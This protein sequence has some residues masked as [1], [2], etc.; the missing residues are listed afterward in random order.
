[1]LQI[2]AF[3]AMSNVDRGGVNKIEHNMDDLRFDQEVYIISHHRNISAGFSLNESYFSLSKEAVYNSQRLFVVDFVKISR[4][5]LY[6]WSTLRSFKFI[7]CSL[8]LID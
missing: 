6:L 7:D 3:I 2:K 5:K 4:V 8:F 1:M